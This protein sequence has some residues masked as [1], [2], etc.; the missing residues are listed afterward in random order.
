MELRNN[1]LL[2]GR[3]L[4]TAGDRVANAFLMTGLRE[5]RAEDAILSEESPD[6]AE[7]L[8]R[9]R[10]WIIDPLDGT[11]EY[12][13]GR[14]DWAVHVALAIAGRPE[15]GA[16][17]IPARDR[18]YRSDQCPMPPSSS[19]ARP[20][21]LV[22]PDPSARE[23]EELAV[24]RCGDGADGPTGIKVMAVVASD[25]DLYYHSGSQRRGTITRRRVALAG[26]TPAAST[27]RAWSATARTLFRTWSRP[28]RAGRESSFLLSEIGAQAQPGVALLLEREGVGRAA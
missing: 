9:D 26:P 4:G 27:A 12:G 6:K 5:W 10:V 21:M 24:F 8:G 16:V 11:R 2:E 13:E 19:R 23:A 25:T 17:A 7:R 18:L 20:L 22:S 1:R 15:I 14:D 3:T 28:Q